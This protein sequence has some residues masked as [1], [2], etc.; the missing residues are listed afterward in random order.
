MFFPVFVGIVKVSTPS[1]YF[2]DAAKSSS[3][4]TSI[5]NRTFLSIERGPESSFERY[6]RKTVCHRL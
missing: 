2:A 6:S 5:G 4:F 3:S 1:R